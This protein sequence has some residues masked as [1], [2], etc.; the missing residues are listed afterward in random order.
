MQEAHLE[1]SVMSW[2]QEIT[3]VL[4]TDWSIVAALDPSRRSRVCIS[5]GVMPHLSKLVLG[6][7][8]LSPPRTYS[9]ETICGF[10]H[11]TPPILDGGRSSCDGTMH[12]T[13]SSGVVYIEISL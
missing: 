12:L 13:G 5:P 7:F 3:T 9:R 1:R 11:I 8:A 4:V 6:L 10:C 2:H